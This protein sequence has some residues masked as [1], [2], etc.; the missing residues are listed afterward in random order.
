MTRRFPKFLKLLSISITVNSIVFLQLIIISIL[1]IKPN[2]RVWCQMGTVDSLSQLL[3]EKTLSNS[4]RVKITFDL[5]QLIYHQDVPY[6]KELL[7]D[8]EHIIPSTDSDSQFK[9]K[10]SLARAYSQQ[11]KP[12]SAEHILNDALEIITKNTNRKEY[13][14]AQGLNGI[15]QEQKGN[16]PKAIELYNEVA[17]IHMALQDSFK[18]AATLN[19]LGQ[20]YEY[21]AN[22]SAALT[23]FLEAL[24]IFKQLNSD[25]AVR[26]IYTNIGIIKQKQKSLDEALKYHKKALSFSKGNLRNEARTH[27]AIGAIYMDMTKLDSSEI[28]FQ[29]SKQ[30]QDQIE[31][32]HGKSTVYNNIGKLYRL[33]KDYIKGIKYN[34]TALKYATKTK[35]LVPMIFAN[36]ELGYCYKHLSNFNK[37]NQYF[38][39]ALSISN[40]MGE[41]SL[42]YKTEKA[43]YELFKNRDDKK[44]LLHYEKAITFK[45]SMLNKE[46][47]EEIKSIELNYEFDKERIK[48]NQEINALHLE[49][50]LKS[51][52]LKNQKNTI[53]YLIT[54]ILGTILLSY[55]LWNNFK[56]KKSIAQ[57]E[58]LIKEQ[59][60]NQLLKENKILAMSSMI[61]G[62]EAERTRIA[63]DLH[64]GLGGLLAT[65]KVKFGII[66]KEIEVLESMNVYQQTST[67]IDNACTEV[68]KIAHNM[69]PDSLTKLGLIE[70]VRDIADYTNDLE[71]KVINLGMHPIGD[72]EQIMLYRVIQE[73]I[74]NS[75]K[76]AQAT[77][78]IIQFSSDENQSNIYLEDDGQGFD[79]LNLTKDSG[80]GLKSMES[81]VNYINGTFELDSV[82]GVGTT[83]QIQIPND[84]YQKQSD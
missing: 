41:V 32:P 69:M 81:R 50:Q 35:E 66:Q 79:I 58:G 7:K 24:P 49:D 53:S 62:Q 14:S 19:N 55:L 54:F 83:V 65:I 16:L 28:Y 64:D 25:R 15:I 4:N 63:R 1:I 27:N 11:S 46:T 76:H 17:P 57:Q 61:E 30:I 75:R 60:I 5:I 9:F 73:F 78:V 18:Y 70:A 31:D 40:S 80:L 21:Q 26:S 2:T 59:R 51:S 43:I 72:T 23:V 6:T 82:I 34:N 38:Q 71:V 52:Q 12:D 44:A 29:R 56:K 42:Q 8:I 45:D 77:N 10:F 13:A 39:E 3:S 74:N 68:R 36:L 33:R 67:M 84:P 22:Y 20:V 37:S 48:K 47:I